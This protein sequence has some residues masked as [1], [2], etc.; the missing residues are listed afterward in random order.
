MESS[1][2]SVGIKSLLFASIGG[3]IRHLFHYECNIIKHLLVQGKETRT[4]CLHSLQWAFGTM[5]KRC[6]E[7]LLDG[8]HSHL[9]SQCMLSTTLS[10]ALWP[11]ILQMSKPWFKWYA[12]DLC[13]KINLGLSHA[14]AHTLSP[15]KYGALSLYSCY[16]PN[17]SFR[18][19]SFVR[20]QNK[21][22]EQQQ[23]DP[24]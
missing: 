9:L 5:K 17:V 12:Q 20:Q 2:G 8:R 16:N 14:R 19:L 24:P 13:Q 23:K 1:T 10:E 11:P 4:S 15:L 3:F 6:T 7:N 18:G 21:T 22:T